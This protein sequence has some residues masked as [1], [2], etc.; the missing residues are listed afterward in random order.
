MTTFE[1]DR[2]PDDETQELG[3]GLCTRCRENEALPDDEWC[4]SC[5]LEIEAMLAEFEPDGAA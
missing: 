2:D 5:T 1:I 4:G 3:T